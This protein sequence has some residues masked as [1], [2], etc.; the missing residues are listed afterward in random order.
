MPC[1]LARVGDV[2]EGNPFLRLL[3]VQQFPDGRRSSALRGAGGKGVS[4][5][6]GKSQGSGQ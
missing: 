5:P 4:Q 6:F 2:G 3:G 1:S